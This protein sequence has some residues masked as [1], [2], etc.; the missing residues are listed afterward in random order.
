MIE[1]GTIPSSLARGAQKVCV[2]GGTRR[3]LSSFYYRVYVLVVG[4]LGIGSKVAS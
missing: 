3:S 2:S 4:E 1:K